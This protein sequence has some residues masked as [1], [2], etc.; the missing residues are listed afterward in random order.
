MKRPDPK[1]RPGDKVRFIGIQPGEES[2]FPDAMEKF[3]QSHPILTIEGYI[4]FNVVYRQNEY[5]VQGIGP[6]YWLEDWFVPAD[7]P[8]VDPTE[9]L[10]LLR[11][12]GRGTP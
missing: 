12:E 3:V 11:S 6:Y 9:F 7:L 2:F 10:S 8:A 1:F 4:D 5:Y